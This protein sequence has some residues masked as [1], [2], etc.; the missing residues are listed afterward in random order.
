[1]SNDIKIPVELKKAAE[2]IIK[3]QEENTA[4]KEESEEKDRQIE[5]LKQQLTKNTGGRETA[6]IQVDGL[7][8][9]LKEKDQELAKKDEEITNLKNENKKLQD[10]KAK[11]QSKC[12]TYSDENKKLRQEKEVS[13]D[14]KLIQKNI[15]LGNENAELKGSVSRLEELVNQLGS[16]LNNME[17]KNEELTTENKI[18]KETNNNLQIPRYS[19]IRESIWGGLL[20]FCNI[21]VMLLFAFYPLEQ[22]TTYAIIL[23]IFLIIADIYML[24]VWVLL[25]IYAWTK[26]NTKVNNLCAGIFENATIFEVIYLI[27]LVV[28]IIIVFC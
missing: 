10:E 8:F 11:F 28:L 20:L 25:C 9:Q 26:A 19:T 22:N 27:I 13:P 12:D 23:F 24:V 21:I 18:L 4:I 14:F 3:L 7:F 2:K 16:D 17:K 1:M 15:K 6:E 5:D